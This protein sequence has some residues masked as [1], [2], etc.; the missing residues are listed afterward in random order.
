MAYNST[1]TSFKPLALNSPY[2][3][4]F[5]EP[6]TMY[7][8]LSTAQCAANGALTSAA[9]T[10]TATLVEAGKQRLTGGMTVV[11][12]TDQPPVTFANQNTLTAGPLPF[13]TPI[14]QTFTPGLLGFTVPSGGSFN[15]NPYND[16]MYAITPTGVTA[17]VYFIDNP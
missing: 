1:G 9:I 8:G 3:P 12:P 11:V 15:L 17:T 2:Q 4:A 14:S 10:A 5:K 6:T 16:P 7:T 13:V